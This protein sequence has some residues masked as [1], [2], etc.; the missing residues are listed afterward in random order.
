MSELN[1][2]YAIV[3][4][5]SLSQFIIIVSHND[6]YWMFGFC[7]C[8]LVCCR[9]RTESIKNGLSS[10]NWIAFICSVEPT[11]IIYQIWFSILYLHTLF[12]LAK[13]ILS[14]HGNRTNEKDSVVF[15]V[16]VTAPP[17]HCTLCYLSFLFSLSAFPVGL[18]FKLLPLFLLELFFCSALIIRSIDTLFYTRV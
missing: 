13:K 2:F 14:K 4:I 9:T 5:L 17:L 8:I 10:L 16:I 15:F 7:K 12:Y 18:V 3:K 6:C 11:I 1:R